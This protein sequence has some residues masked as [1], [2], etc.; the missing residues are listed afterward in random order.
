MV[1]LE[2]VRKLIPYLIK[3]LKSLQSLHS[4]AAQFSETLKMMRIE[5]SRLLALEESTSAGLVEMKNAVESNWSVISKNIE[6]LETRINK[7][8]K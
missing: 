1:K 7:I 4:E 5:Q 3:R 6:A 8:K 2:P